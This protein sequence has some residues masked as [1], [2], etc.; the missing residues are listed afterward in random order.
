V[1]S[2]M[3]MSPQAKAA[4]PLR[5][6]TAAAATSVNRMMSPIV[7]KIVIVAGYQRGPPCQIL[8]VF[9]GIFSRKTGAIR[10]PTLAAA[11]ETA[12]QGGQNVT[13]RQ[14]LGRIVSHRV[15][16]APASEAQTSRSDRYGTHVVTTPCR[17]LLNGP[18]AGHL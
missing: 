13:I 10:A 15:A 18:D 4:V 3:Y 2:P 9:F 12:R 11:V 5:L 8:R 14:G 16:P 17:G 1:P 7:T 6:N